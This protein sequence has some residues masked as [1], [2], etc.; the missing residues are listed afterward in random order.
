[1][2]IPSEEL[3]RL[4][5]QESP[6]LVNERASPPPAPAA[7]SASRQPPPRSAGGRSG[8]EQLTAGR[9]CRLVTARRDVQLKVNRAIRVPYEAPM[10][11]VTFALTAILGIVLTNLFLGFAFAVLIGRGPR[12]LV[13]RR[14]RRHHSVLFAAA[15]VPVRA[16]NGQEEKES[17]SA[18]TP[19]LPPR[20]SPRVR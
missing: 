5:Q 20:R 15:V 8:T 11:S 18:A 9:A 13:R 17:A 12:S 4:L 3:L 16:T 2:D 14:K 1:M 19:S 6:P 10:Y 7:L